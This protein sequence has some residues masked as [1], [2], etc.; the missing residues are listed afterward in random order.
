MLLEV[1]LLLLHATLSSGSIWNHR[2]PSPSPA[3]PPSLPAW[4]RLITDL[5]DVAPVP[6]APRKRCV[7]SFQ[8]A[9]DVVNQ[10]PLVIDPSGQYFR[11][12]AHSSSR[13]LTGISPP[14]EHDPDCFENEPHAPPVDFEQWDAL[15]EGLA[16]RV[17]HFEAVKMT[18]AWAVLTVLLFLLLLLL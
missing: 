16:T 14:E 2:L 6:V 1:R 12:D 13:F 5:A 4:G 10:C 17:P 7:F 15:W 8:C 9:P 18:G 11:R 3:P